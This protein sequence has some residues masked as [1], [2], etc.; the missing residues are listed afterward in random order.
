MV[1]CT[2]CKDVSG[3]YIDSCTLLSVKPKKDGKTLCKFRCVKCGT[4]IDIET[5][6]KKDE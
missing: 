3:R 4:I 1:K 6:G 2:K 5:G